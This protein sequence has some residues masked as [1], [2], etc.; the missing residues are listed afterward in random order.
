MYPVKSS[1]TQLMFRS[2]R[3]STLFFE[4]S[5][6]FTQNPNLLMD[7]TVVVYDAET[8]MYTATVYVWEV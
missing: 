4:M 3:L 5:L 7:D 2:D 8:E 1:R 6:F